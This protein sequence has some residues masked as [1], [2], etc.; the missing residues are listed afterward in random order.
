MW[1]MACI[2]MVLSYLFTQLKGLY[3]TSQHS[4]SSQLNSGFSILARDTSKCRLKES[5]TKQFCLIPT[6]HLSRFCHCPWH[7]TWM[8][9]VPLFLLYSC[10]NNAWLG[11]GKD[12]WSSLGAK[13]TL[14]S[15]GKHLVKVSQK[16]FLVR[17]RKRHV[18][19]D[20]R[21]EMN[22]GL[23]RDC[24]TCEGDIN[25]IQL[26][27]VC[28]PPRDIRSIQTKNVPLRQN[29]RLEDLPSKEVLLISRR[30]LMF[31]EVNRCGQSTFSLKLTL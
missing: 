6:H 27:A 18:T 17:I 25:V 20:L 14:L 1:Q 31:Q 9:E 30:C 24:F 19:L 28:Q 16:N 22:S 13:K 15:L 12:V 21:L 11:L 26:K 29:V 7:P 23:L 8:L 3:T 5:A 10:I 4:S 2:Y